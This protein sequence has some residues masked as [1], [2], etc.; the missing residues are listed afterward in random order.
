[1]SGFANSTTVGSSGL[2]GR[3]SI[4]IFAGHI[5]SKRL[6]VALLAWVAYDFAI[7]IDDS[8]NLFWRY[9]WSMAK[10]LYLTNRYNTL[11]TSIVIVMQILMPSP[12]TSFCTV[13]PWI[14][15][16]GSV[17]LI[18][19]IDVAMITRV[20]ALWN[21]DKR[22]LIGTLSFFAVQII[23]YAG[24][25]SYSYAN[26]TIFPLNLPYTGCGLKQGY[27]KVW[28]GFIVSLV[29]EAMIL[30]L[31]VYK[32]WSIAVQKGIN[33][34]L[35]TLILEE[36]ILFFIII[37]VSQILTFVSLVVPSI[38][39]MPILGTYPSIPVTCSRL[40]AR[41]QRLLLSGSRG[42]SGISTYDIW[43]FA[44]P[45]CTRGENGT[46]SDPTNT[47]LPKHLL[48]P[49]TRSGTTKD[50]GTKH[51]R[52]SWD[53]GSD[54]GLKPISKVTIIHPERDLEE[55][56]GRDAVVS[57]G[58]RERVS[59]KRHCDRDPE[60]PHVVSGVEVLVEVDG[61]GPGPGAFSYGSGRSVLDPSSRNIEPA[62]RSLGTE[63]GSLTI[64]RMGLY[65]R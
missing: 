65:D 21:R 45:D 7:T 60:I 39:T 56:V 10:S 46:D 61:D 31:N 40:F 47:R 1:M 19:I 14:K 48:I 58:R 25:S 28:A 13:T 59:V 20:Y 41:L 18:T 64:S 34:P 38:K 16:V 30:S 4:P 24:L 49:H 6:A 3:D 35:Y 43:S 12:S 44:T 55:I 9:R 63:I 42:Q 29:F 26:A 50:S 27:D 2:L 36:G 52:G 57:G 23:I 53:L 8:V 5:D 22:I 54:I 51:H 11:F 62:G 33:A 37:M 32:S 15:L 17:T